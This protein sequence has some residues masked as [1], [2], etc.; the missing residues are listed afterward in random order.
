MYGHVLDPRA[1]EP[2]RGAQAAAVTGPSPSIC[3]ALSTALLVLGP[4]WL[5]EMESRFAGYKGFIAPA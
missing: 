3:E 5:P 1:G 2:V 4:G